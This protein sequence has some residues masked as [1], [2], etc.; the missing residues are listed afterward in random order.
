MTKHSI[1]F[2][3]FLAIYITFSLLFHQ[4]P[5]IDWLTAIVDLSSFSGIYGFLFIEI[6]NVLLWTILLSL[7]FFISPI[8]G[9]L[10]SVI[11]LNINAAAAFWMSELGII[12]NQEILVS[13]FYTDFSEASGFLNQKFALQQIFLGILPSVLFGFVTVEPLKRTKVLL[14]PALSLVTL[15]IVCISNPSLTSWL[16]KNDGHLGARLLPWSYIANSIRYAQDMNEGYY[17]RYYGDFST[18]PDGTMIDSKPGLVVLVIGESARA[19]NFSYYGYERD[20][21]KNTRDAGFIAMPKSPA[22]ATSTMITTGC[23]LSSKGRNDWAHEPTEPLPSYLHR[24]G[25]KTFVRTNNSEMPRLNVGDY[26][27]ATQLSSS[28]DTRFCLTNHALKCQKHICIETFYDNML[29][30]DMHLIL[31]ASKSEKVFL[32][33]HLR[34]SHGPNYADRSPREFAPFKPICDKH[35]TQCENGSLINSYDNTIMFTDMTL[36]WLAEILQQEKTLSSVVLYLSDHGE[37]L[38]EAGAYMHGAKLDEAP[39][40]QLEIPFLIWMSDAFKES[41]GALNFTN[42]NVPAQDAIFHSVL[43]ALN[44]LGGPYL[45]DRDIFNDDI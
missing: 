28:C 20:T 6:I 16:S 8:F 13:I 17:A 31:E 24:L 5:L 43:G 41:A 27:T 11:L 45:P 14:Y 15:V 26:K 36:A 40:E 3:S 19:A 34:G 23:I 37:S 10:L 44:I 12:L 7:S 38:G 9:K 25:V 1:S 35:V 2:K 42:K 39:I 32:L 33:M 29:L 22:C 30:A 4:M 18:L 21:N